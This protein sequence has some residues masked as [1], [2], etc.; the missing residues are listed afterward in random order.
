MQVQS[1]GTAHTPKLN[2]PETFLV[3]KLSLN[4]ISVGQLCELGVNLSFL[5]HGCTG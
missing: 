2:L 1:I 5:S 4:L 3:P